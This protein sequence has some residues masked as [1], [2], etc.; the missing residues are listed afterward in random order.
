MKVSVI[1]PAHN[2][3]AYIGAVIKKVL[4][5]DYPDFEVIFVD[6]ASTDKTAEIARGFGVKVL[7]ET[8][9]G[10]GWARECGRLEAKGEII[11]NLDADCLPDPDWIKKGVKLF[12]NEKIYAVNGPYDYYDSN[13]FLRTFQNYFQAYI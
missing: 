4:A 11:A 5:L 8:R 1:I 6:N 13:K 3:E 2:E 10:T 7:T 9:K 12:S